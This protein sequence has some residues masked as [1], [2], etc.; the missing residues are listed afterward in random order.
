MLKFI[1]IGG[2]PGVLKFAKSTLVDIAYTLLT[3]MVK[4]PVEVL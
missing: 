4:T 1:K 3:G 2:N